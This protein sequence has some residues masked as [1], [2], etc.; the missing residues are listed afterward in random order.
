MP[1]GRHGNRGSGRVI[2][3]PVDFGTWITG[4]PDRRY[5]VRC[6]RNLRSMLFSRRKKTPRDDHRQRGRPRRAVPARSR[7]ASGRSD[8][9]RGNGYRPPIGPPGTRRRSP[10]RR[11]CAP[12]ALHT[13]AEVLRRGC[14]HGRSR[15][16]RS[17]A[18]QHERSC[19]AAVLELSIVSISLSQGKRAGSGDSVEP[20][21]EL[22]QGRV[23]AIASPEPS[24]IGR[25]DLAQPIDLC[26]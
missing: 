1:A 7:C 23:D 10:W 18:G 15:P 26:R 13:V 5:S 22:L 2:E 14:D 19:R 25:C 6:P 17:A 16:G 4:T 9:R 24:V 8:S 12:R 3:M 11:D 21:G 20:L